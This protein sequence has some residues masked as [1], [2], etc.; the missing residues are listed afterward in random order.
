MLRCVRAGR[1]A[2]QRCATCGVRTRRAAKLKFGA[3]SHM[4]AKKWQ[5][6]EFS[7]RGRLQ[8]CSH[9]VKLQ[10]LPGEGCKMQ[11]AKM[12]TLRIELRTLAC[13]VSTCDGVEECF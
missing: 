3:E 2:R 12:S 11:N 7:A 5:K 13:L 10:N 1:M 9:C 4:M 6:C 8:K